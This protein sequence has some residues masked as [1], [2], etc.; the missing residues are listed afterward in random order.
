M[1]TSSVD[2]HH[3]SAW[4]SI[5]ATSV[6]PYGQANIKKVKV[7]PSPNDGKYHPPI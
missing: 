1:A 3:Q 2:L 4:Q 7:E 5:N 6:N